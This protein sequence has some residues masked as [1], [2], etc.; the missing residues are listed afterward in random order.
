MLFVGPPILWDL[1]QA[2]KPPLLRCLMMLDFAQTWLTA[3]LDKMASCKTVAWSEIHQDFGCLL[4]S[5]V[6][7]PQ[8][9]LADFLDEAGKLQNGGTL[10]YACHMGSNVIPNPVGRYVAIT[11]KLM[12]ESGYYCEYLEG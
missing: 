9:Q 8:T 10:Q 6:A 5:C 2:S 7:P 1:R 4:C 12:D 3:F 11:Q